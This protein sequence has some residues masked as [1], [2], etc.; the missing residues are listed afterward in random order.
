MIFNRDSHKLMPSDAGIRYIGL[1]F[2]RCFC[3]LAVCFGFDLLFQRSS[4]REFRPNFVDFFFVVCLQNLMALFCIQKANEHIKSISFIVFI[5]VSFFSSSVF[6]STFTSHVTWKK[7]EN[8]YDSHSFVYVLKLHSVC[9][10]LVSILFFSAQSFFV[11][12]YF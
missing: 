4:I 11:H 2:A 12:R 1:Y 10:L 5:D 9:S 3:N 7:P 8:D 6:F